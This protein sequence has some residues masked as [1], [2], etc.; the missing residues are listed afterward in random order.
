MTVVH[1]VDF[2]LFVGVWVSLPYNCSV[3]QY[4]N[5]ELLIHEHRRMKHY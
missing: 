2:R 5:I 4:L 1:S 3:R